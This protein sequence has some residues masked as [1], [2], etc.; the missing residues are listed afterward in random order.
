[1]KLG[2]FARNR[3]TKA[4]I[5]HVSISANDLDES[6]LFYVEVF[7]ATAIPTPNFGVPTRWLRLAD[8]QIHLFQRS[9]VAAPTFHH[10]AFAVD[11]FEAVYRIAKE[12]DIFDRTS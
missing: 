6:A 2:L 10:I 8:L 1:M 5:N 12:R 4:W 9:R 11:D 3:M 7:G